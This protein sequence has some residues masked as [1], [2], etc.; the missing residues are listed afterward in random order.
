MIPQRHQLTSDSLFVPTSAD[1]YV[2]LGALLLIAGPGAV[3]QFTIE[4]DGYIQPVEFPL[5][6]QIRALKAAIAADMG[7]EPT[8]LVIRFFGRVAHAELTL[9]DCGLREGKHIIEG[10]VVIDP[11]QTG[12]DYRMPSVLV[13]SVA[14]GES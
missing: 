8:H 12:G 10:N 13:V 14:N 5:S 11:T 7:I 9:A 1:P 6:T 4:P 3:V 2:V